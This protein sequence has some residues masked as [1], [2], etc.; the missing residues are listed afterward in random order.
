MF[1]YPSNE[2][3]QAYFLNPGIIPE[4]F[5]Y[6]AVEYVKSTENHFPCDGATII[7]VTHFTSLY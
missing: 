1:Q 3:L 4:G 2:Y 6:T 7:L 5:N